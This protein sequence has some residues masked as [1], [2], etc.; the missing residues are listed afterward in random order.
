MNTSTPPLGNYRRRSIWSVVTLWLLSL[1]GLDAAESSIGVVRV[2]GRIVD[3]ETGDLLPARLYIQG[4]DGTWHFPQSAS[5]DGSAVRYERQRANSQSFERHTTLSAHPFRVE[6]PSG[7]YTF[8]AVRGKEY[9]RETREVTVAPAMSIVSLP[10]RRWSEVSKDGWYSGDTHVHRPPAELANVMLAEDVNV[11]LPLLDWTI[12]THIPVTGDPRSMGDKFSREVV[13]VDS[14]HVWYP[15]NTEFEIFRVDRR[16][17]RL[18][19]MFVLNH[20]TRFMGTLFPIDEIIRQAR[21]EGALLDLE[22]HN[23]PWTIAMVP[24]LKPDVIEIA[25]NHHWEVDYAVKNWAVPAP[26]WMKLSGS[27]TDTERDWTMYG[28][29]SYYALLNCGFRIAPTGGSASGV[30]PVPLGFSRVYVHLDGP[31]SSDAWLRGLAAGRSFV[32]T[33]PMLQARAASQWP[34]ATLTASNTSVAFD[35]QCEVRSEQPLESI[36]LIVNGEVAARFEPPNASEAGVVRNTVTTRF[37][38]T[39]TSWLAWRCF[40]RHP[41]GRIRFAHTAPWYVTAPGKPL[42]PRRVEAEWLVARVREEI[43]RSRHVVPPEF[44]AA[45]ERSLS[46]YESIAAE[47]RD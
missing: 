39:G 21:A 36:E 27:G 1:F 41:G 34:G 47:A 42:R 24:I 35:L 5:A 20:R 26:A 19:A 45:Y 33:G 30:H 6:L 8:T 46:V 31:F 3:A 37:Q 10:L 17:H 25:N 16:E 13:Q 40:E 9:R 18:G 43:S 12:D 29:Q 32:T 22:K 14:T 28:L 23:W 4:A 2:E 7:R 15:R 11:A 38:P 44:L